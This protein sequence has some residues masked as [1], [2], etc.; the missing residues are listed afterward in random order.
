MT[1]AEKMTH[2]QTLE[3]DQ[4]KS[5]IRGYG[6]SGDMYF[7]ALKR[8]QDSFGNP[9]KLVTSFLQR[10]NCHPIPTLEQPDSFTVYSNFLT[11]LVDTFEQLDFQHD[12]RSTTN[13]QQALRK[14]LCGPRSLFP[15]KTAML[16]GRVYLT[17]N[18]VDYCSLNVRKCKRYST[19]P[20]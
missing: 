13:V 16:K 20:E 2:L 10:L 11:T 19:K 6:Y 17:R 4:A 5:V 7:T 9:T 15:G 18:R 8:L 12:I 14:L 1:T 3:K